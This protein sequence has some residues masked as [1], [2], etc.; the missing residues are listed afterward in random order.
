MTRDEMLSD[1]FSAD[2]AQRLRVWLMAGNRDG[3]NPPDAYVRHVLAWRLSI[4]PWQLEDAPR[5]VVE[6]EILMMQAEVDDEKT[7]R[8]RTQRRREGLIR[9]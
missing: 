7:M 9:P 6:A 1:Y 4:P 5:D 3:I 8:A 2:D